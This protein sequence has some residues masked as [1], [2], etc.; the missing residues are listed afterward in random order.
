MSPPRS[1]GTG[2]TT[3]TSDTRPQDAPK[4]TL[5]QSQTRAEGEGSPGQ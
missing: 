3:R 1:E 4:D 2:L 5:G